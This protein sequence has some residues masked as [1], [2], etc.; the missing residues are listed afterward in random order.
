M[1][2]RFVYRTYR[3]ELERVERCLMDAV[4]SANSS[5]TQS[6]RQ[7]LEAGGKRIRP[8]LA[9]MSSRLGP[10]ASEDAVYRAAAALELVHMASL[11]HD[12]VVDESD[13]RRGQATVRARFGNRA[14][15]YTG[16]F[17]FARSIQLLTSIGDS[18][19]HREMS[20]AMVRMCEGEIDQIRDFYN[21]HQSLRTYLR[22]VE[23]KTALLISVSCS[24]GARVGGCDETTIR[25]LRRFGHYTGMA[26]QIRDDLLDFTGDMNI[27]GKPV[28][29]DLRQ[30]NLTLPTLHAVACGPYAKELRRLVHADMATEE[31]V[32]AVQLIRSSNSLEYAQS[33]AEQYLA[34]AMAELDRLPDQPVVR[35]LRTIAQFV[36]D[37]VY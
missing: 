20:T 26:F 37:R 15:M 10:C 31:V 22:R 21:W 35:E 2:F 14:A 5:M 33:L 19:V 36:N 34:K 1:E 16:D 4:A 25:T 18:E 11:V 27:V 17:L 24:I 30:G 23:R 3:S 6:A 7:L 28:G 12:D 29:G 9:L 8:L 13:V 32:E